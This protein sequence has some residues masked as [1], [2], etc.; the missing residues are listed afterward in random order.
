MKYNEKNKPLVCMQTQ[1]TCYRGTRKMTVVGVLWHDT[2]ANNPNLK[3][4]VQPSDNAS[5]RAEWLNRLGKNQ[6]NN[7]WNHIEHQA[8]LNCWIGKLADGTVTTV[9]TMPWDYRPWGCGSGSKGSCNSGWIQ[10][11]I[12]EDGKT[13]ADYFSK[14]YKEACEIT[15]YLCKLYGIDPNGTVKLN[16]VTVPTIMCHQD[17]YRLGLGSNHSDIYDWFPKFGK[18]METARA[19]VA[20]LLAEESAPAANE[21]PEPAV[22]TA[23]AAAIRARVVNR[24]VSYIGC[25]E[26][27]GSHKKII[28]LYNS[29]KPLARSYAMQYTDAWCATFGSAVAIAEGL[30]DIIPTECGCEEQIKLFKA[31]GRW[32][33]DDAYVP[34]PGDYI[35][36]DWDDNGSGDDTG[37]SDHV[38]IVVSV[39]GSTIRVIEG[40]KSDAVGY[41]DISV[42]GRYI[43]GYGVPD[44]ESKAGAAAPA[45][46]APA[47]TDDNEK[48]IWDKL[49]A[50]IGNAY[51]T[52]GVMG[53]MY[54]ESALKSTNL[55]N[56]FEK[57]LGMTD[58][59]Y[60]A[61]VDDGSYNNFVHDSAGFG[62]VQW[63]FWSLKEG[64]L[65]YA[66]SVGKSIGD[67]DMQVDY[68]CKEMAEEFP[69]VLKVLKNASSIR[70]ASDEVL[71]KFERP[72][73]QSE[74]VQKKR[75]GFGQTYYDKYAGS[76]AP[77]TPAAKL[78]RVRKSWADKASQIGAYSMLQNAINAV[79]AHPG[80]AA[81]DE[82]GTQ[83][84]PEA[85]TPTREK[86]T[87]SY[88]V[89]ISIDDLNIR[90]GPG[91]NFSKTGKY[92]G[93]GVF[94]IV[95]EHDGQGSD[96]GWGRLKSGAGWVSLD[97]CQAL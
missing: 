72:A 42:N 16:G 85:D 79:N 11:E 75:A 92:T 97:Y 47:A 23:T 60:T 51:G 58:E 91:T 48:A 49:Y 26:S 87:L 25:K 27:D 94:T 30:T 52:A 43:R 24:A 9:Q 74:A 33:E 84:Y 44:Y 5:D 66:R 96:S 10:F 73:D 57:S 38:G 37:W 64:L 86:R 62:L 41:R 90:K 32:V 15:A 6:Y 3:R 95:E 93:K 68:F 1:S 45:P 18:S 40:N 61:A 14:A 50:F 83:V 4:Y 63:T 19:D 13:D 22:S 76:A 81:F 2:G 82:A 78:Y 80:Y 36:Y 89:K 77:S 70:E 35:F 28:D 59:Q 67:R 46:S 29:H 31:L 17:S 53:N 88:L 7:D 39:T 55:Q 8:G 71:L 54:A 56:T 12:C 34:S 65:G 69:S 20:K 21:K